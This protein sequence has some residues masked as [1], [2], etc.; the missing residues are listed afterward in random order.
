LE[1]RRSPPPSQLAY[2]PNST[3]ITIASS[4]C[5]FSNIRGR[6]AHIRRLGLE[7]TTWTDCTCEGGVH[8]VAK[9][10][11]SQAPVHCVSLDLQILAYGL[12]PKADGTP[13]L[14][15]WATNSAGNTSTWK[16][17]YLATALSKAFYN[18][19]SANY[20][21]RKSCTQARHN[22]LLRHIGLERRVLM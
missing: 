12:T 4:V 21:P 15:R 5:D 1:N 11:I 6:I 10:A 16:P 17:L 2:T 19:R 22:S 3:Q 20:K 7:S 8:L 18:L 9:R 13:P 14:W